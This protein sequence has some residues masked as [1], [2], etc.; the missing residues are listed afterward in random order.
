MAL[1]LPH[2][3]LV[4]SWQDEF[5]LTQALWKLA[6]D[7]GRSEAKFFPYYEHPNLVRGMPAEWI[8]SAYVHPK[9]G[10]LLILSNLSKQ[11][12]TTAVTPNWEMFGLAPDNATAVDGMSRQDIPVFGG[13]LSVRLPSVGWQTIWIRAGK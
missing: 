5:P 11:D 4:R 6:D 1:A 10:A 13:S 7:F 8:A 9:S 3:V 2:D 12:G